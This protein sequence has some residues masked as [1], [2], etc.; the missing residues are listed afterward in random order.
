MI[1]GNL[2][3]HA[4]PPPDPEAEERA[5]FYAEI[6]AEVP[7]T[8]ALDVRLDYLLSRI[9]DLKAEIAG[10]NEV[11]DRRVA[12]IE[13]WR[14]QANGSLERRAWWIQ[15]QIE[16]LA[17]GY[18][19]RGKKSRSLPAGSFGFRKKSDTLE[20]VDMPTA[21][22]FAEANSLEIKRSVNKTP[23]LI[24]FKATGEIPAGTEFVPGGDEFF[25]RAG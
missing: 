21:V 2:I 19:Y 12:M 11:A 9:G 25:V 7:E 4:P 23:L 16:A 5:A 1:A 18:D 6:E 20:I 17:D 15:L 22:A 10:N 13:G 14:A 8:E 24:H 3:A